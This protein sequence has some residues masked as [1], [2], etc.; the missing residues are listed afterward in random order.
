MACDAR[1]HLSQVDDGCV[2]VRIGI[3]G[4]LPNATAAVGAYMAPALA[5]AAHSLLDKLPET[6]YT[7][8][9]RGP[10]Y[11]VPP[12]PP[13]APGARIGAERGKHARH[14]PP[15]RALQTTLVLMVGVATRP[16]APRRR[17]WAA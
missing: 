16:L 13:P 17:S 7:W 2:R 4:A 8:S 15:G 3:G 9:S 11:A 14:A 5:E 1:A 10:T 6:Q 12:P